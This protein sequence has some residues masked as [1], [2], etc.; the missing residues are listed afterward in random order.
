MEITCWTLWVNSTLNLENDIRNSH[1]ISIFLL[2]VSEVQ[3]F[4]S[5]GDAETLMHANYH[6]SGL[7]QCTSDALSKE[8][9]STPVICTYINQECKYPSGIITTLLL[10]FDGFKSDGLAPTVIMFLLNNLLSPFL[11]LW[12]TLSDLLRSLSITRYWLKYKYEPAHS[13]HNIYMCVFSI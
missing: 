6:L 12:E 1:E 11:K 9:C 10:R 3:P 2:S 5:K 8:I 7:L 4:L 13:Y